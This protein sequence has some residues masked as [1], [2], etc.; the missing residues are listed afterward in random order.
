MKSYESSKT[1]M[2]YHYMSERK[3]YSGTR[4]KFIQ[5]HMNEEEYKILADLNDVLKCP[6]SWTVRRLLKE[7]HLKL[8]SKK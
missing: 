4:N 2:I 7:E 5:V 8:M 1:S 6:V 3:A